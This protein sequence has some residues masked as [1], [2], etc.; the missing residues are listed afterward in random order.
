MNLYIKYIWS[1]YLSTL[2][3]EGLAVFG[4]CI[5][6]GGYL[7]VLTWIFPYFLP[8]Y[9]YRNRGSGSQRNR[10]NSHVEGEKIT[11]LISLYYLIM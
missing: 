7:M 8:P 9:F 2:L 6:L 5:N 3:L 11:E 1:V 10:Q 4:M